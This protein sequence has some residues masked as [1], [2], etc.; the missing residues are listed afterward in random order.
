MEKYASIFLEAIT[1]FTYYKPNFSNKHLGAKFRLIRRGAYSEEGHL[2]EGAG[3]V[4]K[5][6]A[7]T[8]PAVFEA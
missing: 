7:C 5:V 4:E 6:L 2:M 3:L 8:D 1:S